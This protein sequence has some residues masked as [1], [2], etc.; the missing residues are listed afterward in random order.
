MLFLTH[1]SNQWLDIN[2][3]NH[4][5]RQV[6]LKGELKETGS[7]KVTLEIKSGATAQDQLGA[8]IKYN[9]E[10]TAFKCLTGAAQPEE[11]HRA[12]C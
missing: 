2:R 8:S 6:L 1:N 11:N 3:T 12:R 9:T 5:K 10:Q 7:R 4:L